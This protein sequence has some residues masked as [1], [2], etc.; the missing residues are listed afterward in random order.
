MANTFTARSLPVHQPFS[1][2]SIKGV[3]GRMDVTSYTTG[4][5]TVASTI[6]PL[7]VIPLGAMTQNGA[8]VHFPRVSATDPTKIQLF[9]AA[10][11]EVANAADGGD[12]DVLILGF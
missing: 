4:G 9:V 7:A 6:T 10:G 3:I 8:A 12:F 11:T 2:G 5:E 1:L